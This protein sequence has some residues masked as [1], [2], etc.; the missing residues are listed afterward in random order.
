MRRIRGR[1]GRL[2]SFAVAVSTVAVL[3]GCGG[4]ETGDP[5]ATEVPSEASGAESFSLLIN[6]DNQVVQDEL[7]ALAEDEC[8]A[9]NDELALEIETVPQAGLDQQLQLLGGQDALPAQFAA[10]GSP[11][12]TKD[13][14]D[15]GLTLDLEAAL[16]DLGVIDSI[17]PA[18]VSTI[19]NLYGGF[20]VLPYQFNIEGVWYNKE[21]FA[22]NG[23]DVP[24]TWEDLV[25]AAEALESAGVQPFSSS[26]AEGWPITR[27]ISGYLFRSLGP[28]ALQQ[29]AD[30]E[31]KLTDPEYVE[32][33]QAIADLGAAGYFGQGVGSVDYNTA[34]A[35]FLTGGAAMFYMGS[36]TLGA[37]NDPA[38]N[39]IGAENIGFF[40]FPDVTGGAGSSDQLP[41]N[42]GLPI[43]VSA[44]SYNDKVG[45]WLACIAEN[46]GAAALEDQ[47]SITGFT[48]NG[49]VGETPVLT[50]LVQE[51]IASTTE[52]TGWFET[53]F[54][55]KATATSQQNAAPLVSGSVTAEEFMSKVQADL[56]SE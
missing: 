10:S 44:S 51:T 41:A 54:G 2:L 17:E 16:T 6:D 15:A 46:Y 50:Q 56:D 19:E 14:H 22:A 31:A 21:I 42:V 33:A 25:A 43:A 12:V 9:A 23:L 4:D 1:T 48:V 3:A 45:A 7:T 13:L 5:G 28:D 18:A 55:A 27:L 11:A 47:G 36:W 20:I 37:F 38:Q 32:A 30:G 40:P 49:D 34:V 24:A 8:V 29:V 52:T 53:L 35:T 26:G 39:E